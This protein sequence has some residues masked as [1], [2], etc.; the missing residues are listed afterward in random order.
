MEFAEFVDFAETIDATTAD[1]DIIDHVTDLFLHA[2]ED[3]PII[4][5]F[6]QGRIF[7]AWSMKKLDIGPN[8]CYE[9]IAR[10]AGHN[11][12]VDDIE[13]RLAEMGDIGDVAA[14]YEFGAQ[15]GLDA[16][17]NSDQSTLTVTDVYEELKSLATIEGEGSQDEKITIL[18]GLFNRCSSMEAKYLA[19]LVLNEMRIGVGEGT[20]RDAIAQAFD[21]PVENVER[22]LQVS[23]D[24]G[25]VAVT[26]RE[27]GINGLDA[28]E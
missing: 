5:R 6:V 17:G 13:E 28:M 3:L 4:A 22:A 15:Q 2:D 9:A 8:F 23:N 26:A 14:S 11:I 18:F 20:V 1:H 21:I 7:P 27:E 25:E 12:S 19:R 24:Y 16:F 10:A